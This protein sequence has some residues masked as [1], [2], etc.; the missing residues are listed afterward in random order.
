MIAAPGR[1]TGLVAASVL[2]VG[3][4][5]CGDSGPPAPADPA[6]VAPADAALYAD[7]TVRPEGATKASLESAFSKLLGT[8]DLG[9]YVTARVN[10][11]LAKDNLSYS[12]DIAPWLGERGAV[13][14]QSF[15][16]NPKAAVILQTTDPGAALDTF[17]KVAAADD[18]KTK[19]TTYK[20]VTLEAGGDDSYAAI[21]GL[22]VGG[23]LDG[24]KAAI[25]ASTGQS[26]A[27]S[28]DYRSSLAGAPSDRVFTAWADP[29]RIISSFVES[30]K[31]SPSQ[32]SQLRAQVG[33]YLRG[34]AAA[35]GDVTKDYLGLEL[36]LSASKAAAP[37]PSLIS[38]FPSDAWFAFGLHQFGQGFEQGLKQVESAPSS[39]LGAGTGLPLD[40]IREALGVDVGNV[41]KWLGDVSGY[42]GG[43]SIISLGGAL[44]ATT[45]DPAASARSLA[46]LEALF[47][48][49]VDVVTRPLGDGRT[50]FSVTPQGSPVQLVFEQRD[51]KVVAGLGQDSV[52]AA[53]S[54]SETLADSPTFK[55]ASDSL[56][57]LEP[58]LYLDFGPIASLLNIPGVSTN[59]NLELAKPYLDRLDYLI[60]GGGVKDGRVL[61]RIVLGVK[62][63]SSESG[64]VA[65]AGAPPYAAVQP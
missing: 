7:A 38:G 61:A 21:G 57:G 16:E 12:E 4:A 62:S 9:H 50:G 46:Q 34:P 22:V 48:K 5:G 35:W 31:I 64:S 32:S 49:D 27:D 47:K 3:V 10:A 55:T 56:A 23:P 63:G 36:S 45:R 59:P 1:L 14:Y 39:E 58:S 2:A 11:S 60:A 19:E 43:G 18:S 25:A 13:F 51:G 8:K 15:G 52:D 40:R 53:L 65:S 42:L 30:G 54:P 33:N 37:G 28:E 6:T 29:A 44:V 20:G 26:L 41:G 17:A 24:V